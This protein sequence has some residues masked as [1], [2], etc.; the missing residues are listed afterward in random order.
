[1]WGRRQYG[2]V[3]LHLYIESL[4]LRSCCRVGIPT[5]QPLQFISGSVAVKYRAALSIIVLL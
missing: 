4:R 2:V 5:S 3:G 1:M